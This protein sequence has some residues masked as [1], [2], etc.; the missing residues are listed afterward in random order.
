MR[1]GERNNAAI[2]A[3]GASRRAAI[4]AVKA[5][6]P[7]ALRWRINRHGALVGRFPSPVYEILVTIPQAPTPPETYP[8]VFEFECWPVRP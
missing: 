8:V 5:E 1:L 3:I 2:I 7:E 6:R 4:K